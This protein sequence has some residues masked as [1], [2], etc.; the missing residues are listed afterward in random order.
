MREQ[1]GCQVINHYGPTETTVGSLT[2]EVAGL[3]ETGTHAATVPIGRPAANT[4]VYV[5]DERQAPAPVGA[6]GE[7]YIG[8]E[9]LARGYVGQPAHTAER[10]VPDPFSGA[11]GRRMYRT[12]DRVRFLPTGEVEFLGRRDAQVKVRGYRIE[13]GEIESALLQHERV[14][15]CV[16][17]T[18][19]EAGGEPR[20]IAYVVSERGAG[21]ETMTEETV[22][23]E[24]SAEELRRHLRQRLP[25]YMLPATFLTL[26]RLPL[27]PNGKLDRRALAPLA[28][29][30]GQPTGTYLAPRTPAEQLLA[31]I[32]HDVLRLRE[33]PVGIDDN[34]FELGGDS[35]LS[36]QVMARANQ[37][38]LRLT[39]RQ[40]FEHPTVAALAEVATLAPPVTAEQG[41]VSG[42]VPLT[43]IQRAFFARHAARPHHWNMALMLEVREGRYTA[44]AVGEALR[45][46]VAHH[47]ALRLRFEETGGGWRQFNAA[48]EPHEFFSVVDVSGLA[49]PERSAEI[50]RQAAAL[51]A[52]LDIG[53]GPL[54]RACYFETGAGE[55][56]GR[57]LI[58][59]HHLAVDGVS[60]RILLEDVARGSEQ[61]AGGGPI[62]CRRRARR[63][64]RGPSGCA[65]TR[66]ARRWRRS[67]GIGSRWPSV[68]AAYRPC[69]WTWRV[70]RPGLEQPGW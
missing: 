31:A 36:I 6:E 3:D 24:L 15:Q 32:W 52:S 56:A 42:E 50:E 14:R 25:D 69:R 10:F 26:D 61:A 23:A 7:L 21:A 12:G 37:A 19:E 27:T 29:R 30:A 38:G 54:V 39:P 60:W 22:A 33:R 44:R 11:G 45:A 9:G 4:R 48:E 51:Q 47:D 59:I 55:A 13:L 2:C 40:L 64:R 17:G 34:F 70:K 63:T 65:S 20:L 1:G 66:A 41:A 57:L 43:P 53:A 67:E 49:Q 62:A 58:V 8:G 16:V 46:V 35:I 28:A 68:R 18:G 5:L